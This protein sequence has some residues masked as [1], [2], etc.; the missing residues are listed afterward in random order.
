ML[1]AFFISGC[2]GGGNGDNSSNA[3]GGDTEAAAP[4]TPPVKVES[5]AKA[6]S[7]FEIGGVKATM[8]GQ[9]VQATLPYGTSVRQM[10]PTFTTTGARVS[11]NGATQISSVTPQDF[12]VPVS[13]LVT[14]NDGST[15]T[16][17][18]TV[19]VA[20]SESKAITAFS[21]ASTAASIANGKI[22]VTLPYGTDLKALVATFATSGESLAVNGT[23]QKSGVTT[24][25]F[26]A[27][28]TYVVTAANGSTASYVVTVTVAPN[29]AKAITAFSLAGV[30]GIVDGQKIAVT[31][32]FGMSPAD[33]VASFTT[34]GAGVTVG[35]ALQ[36]SGRTPHDFSKPVTYVVMAADGS[37]AS[38]DVSVSV[39]PSQAK[40]LT[41]FSLGGVP[42]TITGSSISVTL[43]YGADLSSQI[44]TFTTTGE[45]VSVKGV[46]QASGSTPQ[47][48]SQS[49]PLP[50]IVRAADGS[51][52]TYEVIVTVAKNTAKAITSYVLAGETARIYEAEPGRFVISVPYY[53]NEKVGLDVVGS[54]RIYEVSPTFTTTGAQVTLNGIPQ[55]SGSLINIRTAL[56]VGAPTNAMVYVVTAE[57]GSTAAYW[58][59]PYP[60]SRPTPVSIS[61]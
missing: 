61:N 50:Y 60:S 57:D 11:V 49:V 31:L 16:Y 10:A 25:D 24:Q 15:A 46:T 20:P 37:V 47:N 41:A 2:G 34:T 26:S 38:Y 59:Y 45:S 40:A 44:A 1:V 4:S 58:L 12:S 17:V 27:K 51:T 53:V 29:Q 56:T 8:T 48:F 22:A 28:V 13:Y 54:Q 3:S 6:L 5:S 19:A 43:P 35:G 39:A 14:A 33:Q 32:P 36:V 52:A 7:A 18:V 9:Q 42:A 30:N 55:T 23:V 21:I